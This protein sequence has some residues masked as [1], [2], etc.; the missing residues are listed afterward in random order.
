MIRRITLAAVLAAAALFTGCTHNPA[1][2]FDA[3]ADHT[4]SVPD[5]L[6]KPG[7][8]IKVRIPSMEEFILVWRTEIGF[9]ASQSRCSYC[10]TEI[11]YLPEEG[12]LACPSHGCRFSLDGSVLKGPAKKPLRAYLVDLHGDRLKILG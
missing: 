9:G 10:L 2:E 11:L 8:Q 1:P 5:A 6:S 7:S 3:G 12:R 4:L